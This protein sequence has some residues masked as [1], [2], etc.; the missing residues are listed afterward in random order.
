[1]YCKSHDIS[2]LLGL[3]FSAF[4]K[5]YLLMKENYMCKEMYFLKHASVLC[6]R[7]LFQNCQLKFI[8]LLKFVDTHTL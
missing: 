8:Y 5:E 4:S 6:T 3:S 1:V 2:E 7:K